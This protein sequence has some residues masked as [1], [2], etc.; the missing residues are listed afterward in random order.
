MKIRPNRSQKLSRPMNFH[1]VVYI[2]F[3]KVITSRITDAFDSNQ[4]CALVI[5][6]QFLNHGPHPDSE[7]S[8]GEMKECRKTVWHIFTKK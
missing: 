6:K 7:S 4:P 2:L 3:S 8:Y 1:S 5:S